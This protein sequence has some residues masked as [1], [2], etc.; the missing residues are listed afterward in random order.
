MN[1]EENRQ[2][3]IKKLTSAGTIPVGMDDVRIPSKLLRPIEPSRSLFW[4]GIE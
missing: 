2:D 3:E 4:Y 1:W